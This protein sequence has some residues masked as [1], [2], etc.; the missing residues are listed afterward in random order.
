MLAGA[1]NPKG[2]E[3]F[4]DFLLTPEVQAALPDAMYVFPVAQRHA[5]ARRLGD[6][7]RAARRTRYTVDPAEIAAHRD[8]WLREWSDVICR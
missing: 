8:D 7:R 5:A 3:A 6:V 2:A 1:Q 4:V